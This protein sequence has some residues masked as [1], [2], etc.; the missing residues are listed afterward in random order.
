MD[1]FKITFQH[2]DDDLL[3]LLIL[4]LASVSSIYW[5]CYWLIWYEFIYAK[6][7]VM[8]LRLNWYEI[9]QNQLF[10]CST[11]LTMTYINYENWM[12]LNND[13]DFDV[14]TVFLYQFHEKFCVTQIHNNK[15]VC[16]INYHDEIVI[17]IM[18]III[19]I[20]SWLEFEELPPKLCLPVVL[21]AGSHTAVDAIV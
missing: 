13:L 4:I 12:C 6:I 1:S 15:N 16:E 5:L 19:K 20:I 21:V 9:L 10:N 8:A 3:E 17:I 7:W 2:F 14:F 18:I 11:A